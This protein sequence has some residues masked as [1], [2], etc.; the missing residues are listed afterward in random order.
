MWCVALALFVPSLPCRSLTS[1][2]LVRL[3]VLVATGRRPFT[4]KLGLK[5]AGVSMEGPRVKIVKPKPGH[6]AVADVA[7][8]FL[9][10]LRTL[11]S[12]PTFP[13]SMLLATLLRDPCLR[14]R[15]RRRASLP[16]RSLVR[17]IVLFE[18]QRCVTLQRARPVTSTMPR[19]PVSFT[20]TPRLPLSVRASLSGCWPRLI[21]FSSSV[22]RDPGQSEDDLKKAGVKYRKGV[23]P[24]M[25]NSRART[26]DDAE[27]LVKVP[28]CLSVARPAFASLQR[29]PESVSSWC[30]ASG[31]HG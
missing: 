17:P 8:G 19:F 5:E 25:A 16:P 31:A 30:F 22:A 20:L 27:G 7:F 23:F 15:P 10:S 24:F 2:L 11:T 13:T 1:L 3:Q 28:I 21:A 9:R 4:D 26:N 14:T 6:V 18:S 29:R 12:A